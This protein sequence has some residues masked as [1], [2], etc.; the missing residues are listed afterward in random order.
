MTSS[1]VLQRQQY[2]DDYNKTRHLK[3]TTSLFQKQI[4]QIIKFPLHVKQL[5]DTARLSEF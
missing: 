5:Q 4:T 2:S 3:Y 1:G